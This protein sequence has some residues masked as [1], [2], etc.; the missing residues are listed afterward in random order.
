MEINLFRNLMKEQNARLPTSDSIQL[1][2]KLFHMWY[3]QSR[4]NWKEG[5]NQSKV[6]EEIKML[7]TTGKI[8]NRQRKMVTVPGKKEI[9]L[10][11]SVHKCSLYF[12]KLNW[13][14]KSQHTKKKT[15][16]KYH[17]S[18]LNLFISKKEKK[19]KKTRWQNKVMNWQIERKKKKINVDQ[20]IRKQPKNM[21]S[22]K[23]KQ[24]K[25]KKSN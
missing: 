5:L 24:V 4:I 21:I 25:R 15:S 2:R 13:Q 23:E 11:S 1:L 19:K 14:I 17:V 8:S 9:N 22:L 18:K 3:K 6:S 20:I 10:T 7:M 16:S 12:I